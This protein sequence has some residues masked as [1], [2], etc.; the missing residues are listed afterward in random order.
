MCAEKDTPL[1]SV[2]WD[3]FLTTVTDVMLRSQLRDLDLTAV[4]TDAL[5]ASV[6]P[7][8]TA[9]RL[10]GPACGMA[11]LL[12]RAAR[13]NDCRAFDTV[14][15]SVAWADCDRL[16]EEAYAAAWPSLR[17]PY[18]VL[19]SNWSDDP[20]EYQLVPLD[21]LPPPWNLRDS[22]CP[23]AERYHTL[24]EEATRKESSLMRRLLN[25]N[26]V[27][28]GQPREGAWAAFQSELASGAT[29][30]CGL[31]DLSPSQWIEAVNVANTTI[32]SERPWD[33]DSVYRA[34]RDQRGVEEPLPAL[35]RLAWSLLSRPI[36]WSPGS[37]SVEDGQ[38]RI[39]GATAA[40]LTEILIRK[41]R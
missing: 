16:L 28:E 5:A 1:A 13:T 24:E 15:A 32:E 26:V 11:E 22:A 34:F 3:R 41:V 12:H 4:I 38:H 33:R 29:T 10:T 2:G 37:P 30:P 7:A 21:T 14:R 9:F 17:Q 27:N 20:N 36:T 23:A 35:E 8:V 19:M 25:R 40:G 31:H 18:G 39:C 6:T